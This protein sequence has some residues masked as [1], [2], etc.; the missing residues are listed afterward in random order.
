MFYA[1]ST[2]LVSSV[3]AS[4]RQVSPPSVLTSTGPTVAPSVSEPTSGSG[5]AEVDLRINGGT[6]NGENHQPIAGD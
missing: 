4:A 3:P 2:T 5:D 6:L 1:P